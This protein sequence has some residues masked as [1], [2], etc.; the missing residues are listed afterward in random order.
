[1]RTE[2]KD[3][4]IAALERAFKTAGAESL[5]QGM[6][7]CSS[8]FGGLYRI[9]EPLK[10]REVISAWF[11]QVPDPSAEEEA[12][13]VACFEML[14]TLIRMAVQGFADDLARQLP[15]PPGGRP[16]TL[17]PGAQKEICAFIGQLHAQGVELREAKKRA[18]RKWDVSV[19]TVQ[20][21]W[22]TRSAS[23]ERKFDPKELLEYLR[24]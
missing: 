9:T 19:R 5:E 11:D 22:S 24:N 6:A 21:A 16:Q 3:R 20:R 1:M 8:V 14:P 13:L 4:I 18:A 2:T 10:S 17:S 7:L 15:H 12:M 23:A